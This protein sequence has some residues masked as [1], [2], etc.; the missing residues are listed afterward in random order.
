MT[1]RTTSST[2]SMRSASDDRSKRVSE[3]DGRQR[4]RSSLNCSGTPN[5][6]AHPR[7]NGQAGTWMPR[8]TINSSRPCATR[9]RPPGMRWREPA[10]PS[11]TTMPI[12]IALRARTSTTA[13]LGYR[14]RR[15]PAPGDARVRSS[16]GSR[17]VT[18]FTRP[19]SFWNLIDPTA[20]VSS[21][22]PLRLAA[23]MLSDRFRAA[24][25]QGNVGQVPE[26]FHEHAVFRSPVLLKP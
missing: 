20:R 21:Q 1:I 15:G 18:P 7:R 17:G 26:L 3:P 25:E 8:T 11:A 14:K 24:V 4:Q 2:T 5:A 16:S 9:T 10:R 6:L 19:A 23:S 13:S 22:R 12:A